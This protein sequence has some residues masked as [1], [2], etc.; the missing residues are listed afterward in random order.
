[1]D[2]TDEKFKF[3]LRETREMYPSGNLKT[4]T[5]YKK[6]VLHGLSRHFNE[7]YSLISLNLYVGGQ[8]IFNRKIEKNNISTDT[9]FPNSPQQIIVRLKEDEN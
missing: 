4:V 1:V 3:G 7:D 6:D 2:V 8:H 9:L 5:S